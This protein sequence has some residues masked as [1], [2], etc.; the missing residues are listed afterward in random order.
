MGCCLTEGVGRDFSNSS[1]FFDFSPPDLLSYTFPEGSG[2]SG[3]KPLLRKA[4]RCCVG[5]AGGC[6]C[7]PWCPARLRWRR[8]ACAHPRPFSS[9][10]TPLPKGSVAGQDYV[11][12]P[13]RASPFMTLAVGGTVSKK[14]CGH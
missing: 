12:M 9:L 1:F 5:W 7:S 2:S 6:G 10:P 13:S 11:V 3:S 14:R 4:P 8:G